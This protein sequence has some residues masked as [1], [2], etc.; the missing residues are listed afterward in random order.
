MDAPRFLVE[1]STRGESENFKCEFV[2]STW[3]VEVASSRPT[4]RQ[5]RVTP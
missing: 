4:K 3:V 1:H 5:V 2:E